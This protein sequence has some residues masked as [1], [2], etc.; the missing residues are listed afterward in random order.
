MAKH[1]IDTRRHAV[2]EWLTANGISPNTVPQ[3]ADLTIKDGP[4][5]TRVIAYEAFVLDAD[6]NKQADER[7]NRIAIETRTAPLLVEPPTWWE[8]YEKPTREDLMATLDRVQQLAE[9][10]RHTGDRK[11]GPLRELLQAL[12]EPGPPPEAP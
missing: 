12:G 9:R 4:G 3:D 10:W 6:G 8:P 1:P 7:G 5:G 2:C 11:N